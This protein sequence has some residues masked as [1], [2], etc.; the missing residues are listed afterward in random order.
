VQAEFLM[1]EKAEEE[2]E[3]DEWAKR[4]YYF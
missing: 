1:L 3:L 2:D 4:S